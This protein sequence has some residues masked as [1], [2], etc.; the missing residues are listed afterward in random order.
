MRPPRGLAALSLAGLLAALALLLSSGAA[1][2]APC[3][4]TLINDWYDGRIDST[5]PLDCYREALDHLPTDVGTYSTARDDINR[6]LQ[7][8]IVA[9]RQGG[10]PGTSTPKTLGP[11]PGKSGGPTGTSGPG[12]SGTGKNATGKGGSGPLNTAIGSGAKDA[13]SLPLP[14]IILAAIGAALLAAG[15]LGFVFRRTQSRRLAIGPGL[16]PAEFSAGD[17][18]RSLGP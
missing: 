3:W 9:R 4:K 8:A 6:A 11:D 7:A 16:P 18:P 13:T 12:K 14:L 2:A 10:G 17:E 15:G 5:Y 1:A